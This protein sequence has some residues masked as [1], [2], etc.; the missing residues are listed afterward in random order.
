M[1]TLSAVPDCGTS[2]VLWDRRHARALSTVSPESAFECRVERWRVCTRQGVPKFYR[3]LSE[4]FPNINQAIGDSTLLP[5]FDNLYLDMNGRPLGVSPSRSPLL[6]NFQFRV[7]TRTATVGCTGAGS[8]R[9]HTTVT[10][11]YLPCVVARPADAVVDV[12]VCRCS[13]RSGRGSRNSCVCVVG[14]RL[15]AL[16]AQASFTT[17]PTATRVCPS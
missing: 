4:R 16:C 2:A 15:V 9:C 5:E 7:L 11:H 13:Q 3:W 6:H 17:L 14:L 10:T 12:V 8:H 1:L